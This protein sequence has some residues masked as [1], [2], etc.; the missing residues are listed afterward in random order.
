MI[1]THQTMYTQHVKR[2]SSLAEKLN[3]Y[4]RHFLFAFVKFLSNKETNSNNNKKNE[5]LGGIN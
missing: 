3:S 4:I 5:Q 1:I 2:T